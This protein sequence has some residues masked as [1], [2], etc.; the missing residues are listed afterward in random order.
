MHIFFLEFEPERISIKYFLAGN[1][2]ID[3]CLMPWNGNFKVVKSQTK[4]TVRFLHPSNDTLHAV[5]ALRSLERTK[6]S[7]MWQN[8]HKR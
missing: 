1:S 8:I 6:N 5:K 4:I 3:R 2:D 7:V